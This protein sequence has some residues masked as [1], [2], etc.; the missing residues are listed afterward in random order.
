MITTG[1]S[2]AWEEREVSAPKV[3]ILMPVRDGGPW[4]AEAIASIRAQTFGDWELIAVDDGSRDETPRILAATRR[5]E[6]R[7]RV[8]STR[9]SARGLVTALNS[10]LAAVR[11][12]Y[13]ARMD[14][15][16][17]ASPERLAA[18]VDALGS[19]PTLTAVTCLVD[20]F[21]E[22]AVGAG[23]R[24]YIAWQN[25]LVTPAELRRDRFVESPVVAPT[26]TMRT[27]FLREMLG[28]W[29]DRDWPED[30]DLVLRAY[31]HHATIARVPLTLHAWRQHAHQA[32][33]ID[34]RYGE[35]RLLAL[36]AHY[37]AR[38]LAGGSV[39]A[40]RS[41][42]IL[43]AGPVG[44]RLAEVLAKEGCEAAGF[45]DVDPRKIGNCVRRAGRTWTVESTA[46]LLRAGPR[47]RYAVAA[48]G[49]SG[50][51]ARIR[52]LLTTAGWVEERDFIAAA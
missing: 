19:S 34:P 18:Q 14:A 25:G 10:G 13:V 9:E 32:T 1:A 26:L 39:T 43:G 28:G 2:D 7:L 15:D 22:S 51:R 6:A 35:E 24:R 40:G 45:A 48:V 50:A 30:W 8:L 12:A 29:V 52:S 37:L 3:S 21:P 42:W 47:E 11:G 33:R 17:L 16:D 36:R 49:Q 44:K 5:T 27:E 31:E 41:I 4:I 20:G 38:F 46:E 23:M